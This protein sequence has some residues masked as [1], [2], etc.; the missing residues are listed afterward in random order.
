MK[1][2]ILIDRL[3]VG[4]VEK[5]AIEQVRSLIAAGHDAELVVMRKKSLVSNV[6][7][8]LLENIPITFLD[9]RLPSIF[10]ASF[11]FPFFH[12]FASFHL[13]YPL[14][15]PFVVKDKEYDYII[16]H[17]TY[18]AITAIAL[19]K[20]RHIP[21]SVFIWDPVS[22]LLDRV[23][24]DKIPA[25]LFRII[26]AIALPFDKYIINQT[27]SVLV[28]GRAHNDF[29]KA[30][31]PK[32]PIDVIYPSVHP[33][34]KLERKDGS[35]LIVTAWKRG[36]NPE[37]LIQLIKSLPTLHIKMVGKWI[38]DDYKAEFEQF[39]L[40]NQV[41]DNIAILGA[42]S[43]EELSSLYA[44]ASVLLQTNDDRGFG[45][46]AIEAAAHGTT[47]IIPKGQ[48]VCD[49]FVDGEDGYY[50]SEGDTSVIVSL[51]SSLLSNQKLASSMGKKAWNK[52]K[53]N[54]SWEQH[55]AELINIASRYT[56]PGNSNRV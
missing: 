25:I 21:F 56:S 29:I 7:P 52:V 48:G 38:E 43:E 10:R 2:G 8:D 49:L 1:I 23:Y 45:L 14:F 37:Y 15:L 24:I 11:R 17:G 16:T 26:K 55:A 20:R 42:V 6:F 33:A 28:G 53:Q 19:K 22:Y 32:K 35:V 34:K 36:K 31:N 44:K 47:F 30:L 40:E 13:S 41:A 3:N 46:P 9:S 50:T 4:G 12:F 18:T 27:D 5:I 51:L 54:Y 39:V